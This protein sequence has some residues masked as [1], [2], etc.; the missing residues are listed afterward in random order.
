MYKSAIA[1]DEATVFYF[2][3]IGNK[4]VAQ[5]G[6]LV[7]RIN[8]PGLVQSR[9]RFAGKN[10]AIGSYKGFA[11]FPNP[12][13][14]RQALIDFLKAKK[15]SRSTL[16]TISK[17]Y[18]PTHSEEYLFKL[19]TLTGIADNRKISS[20]SNEEFHRLLISLEKL[21]GYAPIGDEKLLLLPKI[22]AHIESCNPIEKDAYLIEGNVS[23]SKEETIQWISTHR[24]DG[25][26]VHQEDGNT[27]IR[28]R[29]SRCMWNIHIPENRSR[30][31]QDK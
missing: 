25:V 23:L 19:S 30:S 1:Y 29:P 12:Q 20:L 10:K 2:D 31:G 26:I 11:I 18:Q 22:Y 7:W 28:S 15:H 8:N 14:G 6:T 21:C 5:G 13:R 4:Y 27:H 9:S 24:L 17:H 3:A 16:K